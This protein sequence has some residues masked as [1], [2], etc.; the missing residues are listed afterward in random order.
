MKAF[1]SYSTKDKRF[2]AE[3]KSVFDEMGIE[4]FL[5]HDDLLVSEEWKT[6]IHSELKS[7]KIFVPLLST[8]FKESDWCSQETGIIVNKRGVLV[9]PL[10]LDGTNPYGFISH[11]QGH[12]VR[13]GK[14]DRNILF[15][16][17][18]KKWPGVIIEALLRPMERVHSY[19][20]AE[21]TVAPLVSYFRHFTEEQANK[22]AELSV[23]NGQI[24]SASLCVTKYLPEF[25]KT[26]KSRIKQPL[27]RA[28]KYQIENGAPY[29]RKKA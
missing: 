24:W 14:I 16:A 22:F 20:Q 5:A 27:Y 26:N 25:L 23:K 12:H 1:I 6:R 15:V 7:C 4:S 28:L 3:V 8:A 9:I 2:G 11:I 29:K 18:G 17:V 19:R 21:D 13:D 10:S